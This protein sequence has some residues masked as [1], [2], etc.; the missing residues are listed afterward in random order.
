MDPL[1]ARLPKYFPSSNWPLLPCPACEGGRI[2]V[3][4]KTDFVEVETGVSANARRAD[5][6]DPIDYE[7][8]FVAVLTCGNS[9][10]RE[11][12]AVQGNAAVDF[13]EHG[14][15]ETV[16]QCKYFDPPLRLIRVP[17]DCPDPIRREVD[18]AS[19][20]A[21]VDPGSAATRLRVAVERVL[22]NQRVRKTSSPGKRLTAHARIQLLRQ[23]RSDVA[24][25]LEAVK[26]IGN[27]SVHEGDVPIDALVDGATLLEAAL[28]LLYDDSTVSALRAAKEINKARG[29]RARRA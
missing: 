16:L 21:W 13:D 7:G 28:G 11:K 23:K 12:V 26:W 2:S 22:D 14:H 17:H 9:D 29:R 3:A 19:R 1:L 18:A 25:L 6:W 4:R 24:A 10:C 15:Y 27:Q 20:L 8:R 5:W